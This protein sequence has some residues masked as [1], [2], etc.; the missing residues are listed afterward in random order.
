MNEKVAEAR[1]EV[2]R[3]V[4]KAIRFVAENYAGIGEGVY[5]G[6]MTE[7]LMSQE[8]RFVE[9]E[10]KELWKAFDR[11]AE[12]WEGAFEAG[13]AVALE[14]DKREILSIVNEAKKSGL[15]ER[16]SID[17]M[18]ALREVKDYLKEAGEEFWR[19]TFAPMIEGVV[20]DQGERWAVRLGL[21]FDVQNLYA[22]DW[23]NRYELVFAQPINET[24][25]REIAQI[26]NRAQREGTSAPKIQRQLEDLFERYITGSLPDDPEYDWYTERTPP[27]RTEAIARTETVR[28]S[29]AGTLETFV[30]WGVKEKEWLSTK[31]DR[32]RIEHL[33]VDGQVVPIDEPFIV[34]GEEL[35]YPGDAS[36]SAGN[37]INCRC[38]ELPVME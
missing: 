6:T 17:W 3:V 14:H 24:T 38:T 9:A 12:R 16:K 37:V 33:E 35:M 32:V 21:Q 30:D 10:R 7:L 29:N 2:E 20:T 23:F 36:G 5:D 18:K 22:R 4:G 8:K 13:A 31:D 27:H 28:A 1:G 25:E 26:M 11:T 19:S 15:K 34:G